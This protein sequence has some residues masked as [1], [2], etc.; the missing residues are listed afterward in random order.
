M[1]RDVIFDGNVRGQPDRHTDPYKVKLSVC[2]AYVKDYASVSRIIASTTC[3]GLLLKLKE[4]ILYKTQYGCH[5][6]RN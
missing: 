4:Y 3:M 2:V 1:M 5:K 6:D